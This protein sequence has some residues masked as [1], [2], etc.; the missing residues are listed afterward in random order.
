MP[1]PDLE[2]FCSEVLLDPSLQE[3][4]RN[5]RSTPEFVQRV[6][7]AGASRGFEISADDVREAIRAGHR[8]WLERWI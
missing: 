3:K 7:E 8:V 4:L 6:V 2:Q 5:I 1:S